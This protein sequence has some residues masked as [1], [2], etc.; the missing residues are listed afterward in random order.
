LEADRLLALSAILAAHTSA[1]DD[2]VFCLWD[3][4]G[5]L[6]GSPAV[7]I[8]AS[9]GHQAQVAPAVERTVLEGP[10]VRLPGREYLLLTGPLS[11]AADL[12]WNPLEGVVDRQSPN[13]FWPSDRAWCVATEIDFDSTVVAGSSALIKDLLNDPQ[14]DSWRVAPTDSLTFDA[15][16]INAQT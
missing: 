10:R 1:T 9:D 11:A 8:L 5:Q 4:Y 13:L 12:D 16:H 6:S 3:G 14:L 15:D 2:C 7:A